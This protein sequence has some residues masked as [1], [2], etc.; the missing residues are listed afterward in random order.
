[1][2]QAPG[3]GFSG[4]ACEAGQEARR[5]W[6]VSTRRGSGGKTSCWGGR[7]GA[8]SRT[9]ASLGPTWRKSGP[10]MRSVTGLRAGLRVCAY[11]TRRRHRTRRQKGARRCVTPVLLEPVQPPSPQEAREPAS[12]PGRMTPCFGSSI[13]ARRL[14][15][16]TREDGSLGSGRV[17]LPGSSGAGFHTGGSL[18][19]S[20]RKKMIY[21]GMYRFPSIV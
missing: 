11:T 12:C 19:E 8:G 3:E 18:P 5:G 21:T 6:L 16:A 9:V 4:D 15:L 14:R 13:L 17:G 7:C 20:R 10:R 1:M 2:D